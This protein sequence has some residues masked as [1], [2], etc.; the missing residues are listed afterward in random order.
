M[1]AFFDCAL[2]SVYTNAVL[3]NIMR[4]NNVAPEEITS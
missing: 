3:V 1:S 4:D 2:G